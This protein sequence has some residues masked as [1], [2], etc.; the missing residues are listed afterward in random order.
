MPSARTSAALRATLAVALLALSAATIAVLTAGCGGAEPAAPV[1]VP[2]DVHL[3]AGAPAVQASPAA[4]LPGRSEPSGPADTDGAAVLDAAR[5]VALYCHLVEAGQFVRAGD[6]CGSR[7]LWSRRRLGALSGFHFRS[8][9]VYAAPD[10]R[11][12]VLKARVR[13]HA[14]RGRPLPDGLAV[15]FFTLGRAGSAVGGWLV[16]AVSTSPQPSRKGSL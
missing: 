1:V 10:A 9:S 13:V 16:N 7:R 3:A 11:T 5:T 2:S 15:L 14:G 4:A 6:L 12:L 8:A